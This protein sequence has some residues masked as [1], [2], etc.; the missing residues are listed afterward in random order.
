MIECGA[1]S[2]AADHFSPRGAVAE[3]KTVLKQA[4]VFLHFCSGSGSINRAQICWCFYRAANETADGASRISLSQATGRG[5]SFEAERTVW[6]QRDWWGKQALFPH[7][8]MAWYE[9]CQGVVAALPLA[10]PYALPRLLPPASH[11]VRPTRALR[12]PRC[13]LT[14]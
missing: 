4:A 8:A 1:T 3:K 10:P 5:H 11:L 14:C 6:K 13:C 2:A 12:P 9:C 7:M